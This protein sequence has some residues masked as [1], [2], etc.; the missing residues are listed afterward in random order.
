MLSV[1]PMVMQ[2]L[3]EEATERGVTIQ[4]LI[5]ALIIPAYFKAKIDV[6]SKPS[7]GKVPWAR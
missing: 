2:K 7:E 1:N 4:E 5:R 6:V 3:Q